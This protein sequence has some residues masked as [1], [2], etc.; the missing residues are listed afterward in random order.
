MTDGKSPPWL[1]PFIQRMIHSSKEILPLLQVI[2]DGQ[3]I[4]RLPLVKT[5]YLINHPDGIYHIL[6]SN[7]DNYTKEGTN[8]DS[9]KKMLGAGLLTTSGKDWKERRHKFQ[10][11]FQGKHLTQCVPIIEYYTE[12]AFEQFE[13]KLAS[14]INMTE[15]ML[16]ATMNISA[17][18][19]FGFD[20]SER[21]YEF[22][23]WI[24]TIQAYT[25]R[26]STLSQW[27][28][29]PQ[30][31]YYRQTM[32]RLD[33]YLLTQFK[34]THFSEEFIPLLQAL[35]CADQEG[36]WLSSS[37]AILG[38]AKNFF[39]A[40][41]ETTGNAISWALYFLAKNNYC[42]TEITEEI[43]DTLDDT[44]SF[45]AIDK[46]ENLD[47]IIHETLRLAPPI[48]TLSRK[49]IHDDEIL[50][51]RIPANTL[52]N[53]SPY[54]IHRHPRYWH[55]PNVFYPE[56]FK[57]NSPKR[58]K[59]AY[60]PFGFGPRACIG[61]QF[62]FMMMKIMITR[63]LQKFTIKPLRKDTYV[64]PLPLITLKPNNGVWLKLEKRK[65]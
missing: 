57:T 43:D 16:V 28:P 6:L 22:V 58:P 54:L 23:R 60:I 4:A 21:S 53:I 59:C 31:L 51:Y 14:P 24:H 25:A 48:W 45:A 39:V 44:S 19:F 1:K 27:L 18:S 5:N 42:L 30:S 61:R 17:K 55:Q 38:E 11:S 13:L 62:S 47:L 65:R 40:G 50:G 64:Q 34:K 7:R 8:Y 46:L 12:K 35:F 29:S 37:T 9:L 36:M 41:H 49:A 15:E 20:L 3:D 63:L 52:V 10:D 32:K 26:A 56:R 33:H 2:T